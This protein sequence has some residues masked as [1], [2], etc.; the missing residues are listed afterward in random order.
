MNLEIWLEHDNNAVFSNYTYINDV[1]MTGLKSNVNSTGN[2]FQKLILLSLFEL[3][4]VS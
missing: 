2:V 1:S 4:V 3:N